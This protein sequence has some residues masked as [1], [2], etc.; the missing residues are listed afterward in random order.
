MNKIEVG[1]ILNEIGLLLEL[2]EDSPFKTRAYYNGARIV[3]QL[4]EDLG[5]LVKEKRLADT[6]GIGKALSEKITEL[7]ETGRLPY[8][9]ELK[10]SVD[11]GLL[12][13]L[14][15]PGLGPKKVRILH[16]NLGITNLGQLE[17]ACKENRLVGLPGFGGK[18][19]GKVL[20]GIEY[21]KSMR[22]QFYY[23]EALG[24]GQEVLAYLESYPGV[25]V[26]AVAGSLRRRKEIVK[27]ID[28]V[29]AGEDGPGIIDYFCSFPGIKETISR[30]DTKAAVLL[31][32]GIQVDLRVVMEDQFPY[33]FHHFTGSKEHNASLRQYAKGLGLKINEYGLFRGEEKITCHSEEEFFTALGLQYIPA[34]LREDYGEI[35]AAQKGQIPTLVKPQD[36][37]GIF[38]VHTSYSD[39][40]HSLEEMVKEAINLGYHYIGISDHSQTAFYAH[41]LKEDSLQRQWEEIEILRERYPQ[42]EIIAG[43][44]SDIKIDGSLDYRSSILERFDFVIASV[45]SHFRMSREDMTNRIIAA[46]SNPV[47]TM[48]GHPTGRILLAREGYPLNMDKILEKAREKNVILELNASPARL[49]LDWRYL[50]RAKEMGILISINP[51]AHRIQELQDT[52][53]GVAVARK[54]WLTREDVFNC[55]PVHRVKSYLKSHK[56][57]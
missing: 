43:I 18:T 16:A 40:T 13:I 35:E 54:G 20:M 29:A 56:K 6:P 8:Y 55:F 27:D 30:G 25:A 49:D 14:R 36:I 47:V 57:S 7:V 21:L 42:I 11:P 3:E 9:E 4:Q 46:L 37:Q 2:K 5:Q 50:K 31:E 26:S 39:G 1:R 45:H 24:H 41:G 10:S 52:V 44:E 34:E 12:D 48:L 33:V 22:G 15:V 51:D 53:F 23:A 32:S 38:H 19:Q 28:L 17:Y